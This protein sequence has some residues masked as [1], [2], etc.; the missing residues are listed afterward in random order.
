MLTAE[1]TGS[2]PGWGTKI[3]TS[4]MAKKKLRLDQQPIT[5]TQVKEVLN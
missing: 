3:P 5:V 2:I 1:G 4:Y